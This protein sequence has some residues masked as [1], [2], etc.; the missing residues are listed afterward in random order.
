MVPSTKE[1]HMV[2]TAQKSSYTK[3]KSGEW[4]IRVV[5]AAV[6]AGDTVQVWTKAGV[7]K[8]ET[9]VCVLWSGPDKASGET[10]SLCAIKKFPSRTRGYGFSH[11]GGP[12][13]SRSCYM[14]G[15]YYCDGAR[16]GLCSED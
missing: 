15:S 5:G 9:V 12:R 4:G 6:K 11:D 10:V 1:G 13:G 3:L 7:Q 8:F 2:I 14:C 16:G